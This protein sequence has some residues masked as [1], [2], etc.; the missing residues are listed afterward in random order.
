MY[1]ALNVDEK[2]QLHSLHV[3]RETN[4]SSLITS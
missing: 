4:L 2:N 3:N 1:G